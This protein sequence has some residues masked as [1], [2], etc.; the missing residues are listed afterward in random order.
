[1]PL[2]VT[3]IKMMLARSNVPN[4]RQEG[5]ANRLLMIALRCREQFGDLSRPDLPF[6]CQKIG[7]ISMDG[8]G[9]SIENENGARIPQRRSMSPPPL[10]G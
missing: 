6:N 4:R 5:G 8:K 10:R 9:V 1:M 7:I 3:L 2:E